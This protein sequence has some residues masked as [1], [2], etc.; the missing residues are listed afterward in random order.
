[1]FSQ[2]VEP[3]ALVRARRDVQRGDLGTARLRLASHLSNN[4]DQTDVRRML[5]ELCRQAGDPADAGRWGYLTEL[6]TDAERDAFDARFGG[7]RNLIRHALNDSTRVSRPSAT[8][9]ERL[10]AMEDYPSRARSADPEPALTATWGERLAGV[11]CGLVVLWTLFLALL[12]AWQ[13]SQ[14]VLH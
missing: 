8:A 11:G 12:G 13:F 4:P 5:V 2:P 14:F 7:N 3:N 9:R 10:G 6:A 1:M